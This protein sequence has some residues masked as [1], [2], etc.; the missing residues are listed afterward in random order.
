MTRFLIIAALTLTAACGVDG[1]PEAP[2]SKAA[3]SVQG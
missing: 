1:E 3:K 2:K